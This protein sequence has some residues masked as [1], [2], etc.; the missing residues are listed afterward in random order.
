M[1][2]T[3]NIFSIFAILLFAIT[4]CEKDTSTE[5][6]ST[7]TYYVTFQLEG[8]EDII[9][10]LGQEYE[11]PGYTAM[12]GETDVTA[13]VDV[14]STV[15]VSQ[16]GVYSVNYSAINK[17]GFSASVSRTVIVYDP[18]APDLDPSGTYDGD[19]RQAY[20]GY[21][22]ISYVAKGIFE[23]S[24]LFG[25]IYY[26]GLNYGAAYVAKGYIILHP[27]YSITSALATS[28]WGAEEITD[29]TYDATSG[30]FTYHMAGY[31]S[32]FTLVKQ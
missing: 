13:D 12:E 3:F 28:P 24:D 4:A 19:Y 22:D 11:E 14:V 10:P 18:D 32:L 8:S 16:A 6:I 20:F 1:K 9:I 26:Y 27:D 2:K 15:D 7:I 5:D 29:G 30:T 25:G 17:D 31:G 21:C 23:C